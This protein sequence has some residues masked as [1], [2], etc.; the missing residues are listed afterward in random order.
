MVPG[1]LHGLW[2]APLSAGQ[3]VILLVDEL[4]DMLDMPDSIP[5]PSM[6]LQIR[7]LMAPT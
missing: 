6:K 7:P 5:I 2:P 1:T 3:G 4:D